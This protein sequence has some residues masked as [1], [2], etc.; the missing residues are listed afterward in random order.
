MRRRSPCR[1]PD[2]RSLKQTVLEFLQDAARPRRPRNI[3][4]GLGGQSWIASFL[5]PTGRDLREAFTNK[6]SQAAFLSAA[7]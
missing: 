2:P 5:Q 4:A 7:N 6:N 3:F 1:E